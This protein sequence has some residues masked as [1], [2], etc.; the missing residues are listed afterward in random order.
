LITAE[1]A[2]SGTWELAVVF[3]RGGMSSICT[4]WFGASS[5]HC[6]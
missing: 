5:V 2:T 4:P 6:S 3:D 1:M